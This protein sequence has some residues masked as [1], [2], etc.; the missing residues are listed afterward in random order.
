MNNYNYLIIMNIKYYK[1]MIRRYTF[2]NKFNLEQRLY[3]QLQISFN[4]FF[5]NLI[6]DSRSWFPFILY[7]KVRFKSS[8]M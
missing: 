7:R 2:N 5:S 1:N 6:R 4:L 8:R 3:Y